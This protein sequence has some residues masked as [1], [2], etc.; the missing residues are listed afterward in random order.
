[1]KPELCKK[2]GYSLKD[3]FMMV[4]K[5]LVLSWAFFVIDSD[6]VIAE[7]I[8]L[9]NDSVGFSL[10]ADEGACGVNCYNKYSWIAT[11]NSVSGCTKC[12]CLLASL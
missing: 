4:I 8:S 7:T 11:L 10:V 1:M 9:K 3:T 2:T 6:K 12:M 5:C